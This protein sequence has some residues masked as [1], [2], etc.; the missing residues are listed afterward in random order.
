LSLIHNIQNLNQLQTLLAK[1]NQVMNSFNKLY[2]DLAQLKEAKYM[3]P[4][5]LEICNFPES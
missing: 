2:P 3:I 4:Y 1:M 5:R